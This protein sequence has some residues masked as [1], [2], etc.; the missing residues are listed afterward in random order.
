MEDQDE[1]EYEARKTFQ[2]TDPPDHTMVRMLVNKA[3][4]KP[5]VAKYEDQIRK[6][7]RELIEPNL[8][9][10]SFDAVKNIARQLPMR[11]LGQIM[12]LP[13][14]DM[15]FLV[16]KGDALISN[17]DPD[18]TDFVVDKVDTDEYRL[19]PFRSPSAVELFDYAD[20]LYNL[21]L[22]HI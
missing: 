9:S 8:D 17:S 15:D 3:F 19:L 4:S 5:Q 21:S 13:D 12:N 10:G 11:M 14:K 2:E 20:R 7:T 6:I 16:E 22:I 1:E 18:Y